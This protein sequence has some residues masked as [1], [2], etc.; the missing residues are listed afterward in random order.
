MLVKCWLFALGGAHFSAPNSRNFSKYVNLTP[1]M[2]FKRFLFD[3]RR[4]VYPNKSGWWFASLKS[5]DPVLQQIE[6]L[7]IRIINFFWPTGFPKSRNLPRFGLKKG[8]LDER[9][10]VSGFPT[11]GFGVT[12]FSRPGKTATNRYVF[13]V[14]SCERDSRLP[15][16]ENWLKEK[17]PNRFTL[18]KFNIAP[19]N[20]P[21]Q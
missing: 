1:W 5:W 12:G 10:G 21:P 11:V 13:K 2:N 7:A 15:F 14:E 18:P 4:W 17:G 8:G 20:R 3:E 9:F 19:E 16:F 6:I